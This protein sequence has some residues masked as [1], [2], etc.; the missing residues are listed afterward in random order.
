[1]RTKESRDSK[2][3]HNFE[4]TC[5]LD[6]KKAEGIHPRQVRLRAEVNF[7]RATCFL[8]CRDK[9]IENCQ[10]GFILALPAP[11]FI[12]AK[13]YFFQ[14]RKKS[15]VL[16][17]LYVTLKE[18]TRDAVVIYASNP[19]HFGAGELP[20]EPV[21][22]DIIF[23]GG[24]PEK[25]DT[26]FFDGGKLRRESIAHSHHLCGQPLSTVF[27]TQP[28]ASVA[29]VVSEF[30][31]G[32]HHEAEKPVKQ[33]QMQSVIMFLCLVDKPWEVHDGRR[34]LV[35]KLHAKILEKWS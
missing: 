15:T 34:N 22:R 2:L 20:I 9:W 21:T 1:M 23:T 32:Q 24:C 11:K 10:F 27:E 29:V 4:R 5:L 30:R 26:K 35:K 19:E 7:D 8:A 31:L 6:L 12:S 18:R 28:A 25:G 33:G 13:L 3:N 17:M 16:S 14:S